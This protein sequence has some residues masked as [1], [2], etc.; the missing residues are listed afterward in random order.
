MRPTDITTQNTKLPS[1]VDVQSTTDRELIPARNASLAA[2]KGFANG[3]IVTIQSIN[4]RPSKKKEMNKAV[5]TMLPN[6][7]MLAVRLLRIT[8]SPYR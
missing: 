4:I 1:Y 7:P 8:T 5:V 3:K 6:C 2:M